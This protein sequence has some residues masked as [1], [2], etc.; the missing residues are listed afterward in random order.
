MSAI[1]RLSG[2]RP[3]KKLVASSKN[4]AMAIIRH[5]QQA[6]GRMSLSDLSRKLYTDVQ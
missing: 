6:G 2:M 5:M 4:N 1:D 3:S